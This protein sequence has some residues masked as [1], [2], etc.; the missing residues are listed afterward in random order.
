MTAGLQILEQMRELHARM[1]RLFNARARVH[2]ASLAQFKVLMLVDRSG[3]LRSADIVEALAQAPRTVTEAIDGLER[4]G[5]VARSPDAKDRRAKRITLTEKGRGV[6]R[7]VAPVR[8]A[9]ITELFA[10]MNEADMADLLRLLKA[11]DDRVILMAASDGLA[12]PLPDAGSCK[13]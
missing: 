10:S 9:F 1:Q 6:L 2:G 3:S 7:E 13:R 5:L 12:E 8:D 11:L 4:D